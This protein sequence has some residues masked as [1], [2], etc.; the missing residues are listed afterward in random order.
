MTVPS[1]RPTTVSSFSSTLRWIFF[2][3]ATATLTVERAS[4]DW[5]VDNRY[6]DASDYDDTGAIDCIDND[7]KIVVDDGNYISGKKITEK[8]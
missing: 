7:K 1:S 6:D 2:L 5:Y 4:A 8:R 3:A